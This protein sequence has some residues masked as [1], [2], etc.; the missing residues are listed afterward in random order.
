MKYLLQSV[1]LIYL[2]LLGVVKGKNLIYVNGYYGYSNFGDDLFMNI[3][4]SCRPE[5]SILLFT[6]NSSQ[7]LCDQYNDTFFLPR[8]RYLLRLICVLFANR[9]VIGGGGLLK[10]PSFGNKFAFFASFCDVFIAALIYKPILVWSV[11]FG[12]IHHKQTFF[13]IRLILSRSTL[14][15]FR[16][17]KSFELSARFQCKHALLASDAVLSFCSPYFSHACPNNSAN[18]YMNINHIALA[19]SPSD[20]KW[21]SGDSSYCDLAIAYVSSIT[22]MFPAL[23]SFSLVSSS[24]TPED[25]QISMLVNAFMINHPAISFRVHNLY[26]LGLEQSCQIFAS[27]DLVVSQRYH[28]SILSILAC[29]PLVASVIDSKVEALVDS[30]GSP[31]PLSL[32]WY[33]VMQ[34]SL[35]SIKL[36]S[37]VSN[38]CTFFAS[39]SF[40]ETRQ[41]LM[42][43]SEVQL[44]ELRS[45]L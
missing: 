15:I 37:C 41:S 32:P 43:D 3:I 12:A 4:Q 13:A 6:F 40:A 33:D 23:K 7:I 30:L 28:A 42:R 2:L 44:I 29:V 25:T 1:R 9:V 38:S 39:N 27:F 17:Y 21:A 16:D 8:S 35:F 10:D 31:D 36:S 14:S 26:E 24:D 18:A 45:F 20:L 19:L 5:G 22:S 11:G 34:S